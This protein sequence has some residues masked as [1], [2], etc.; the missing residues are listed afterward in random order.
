MPLRLVPIFTILLTYSGQPEERF[1]VSVR[2]FRNSVAHGGSN[3]RLEVIKMC[4]SG[5]MRKVAAQLS[6]TPFPDVRRMDDPFPTIVLAAVRGC[7]WYT[8]LNGI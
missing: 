8:N 4:G 5:V 6:G 2:E 3:P 7:D 1:K